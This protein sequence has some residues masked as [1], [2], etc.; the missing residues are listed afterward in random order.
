M[1]SNTQSPD[2][3]G[4]PSGITLSGRSRRATRDGIKTQGRV[5]SRRQQKQGTERTCF[6]PTHSTARAIAAE[7]VLPAAGFPRSTQPDHEDN[8][9]TV[10]R[11]APTRAGHTRNQK[12]NKEHELK[13]LHQVTRN[14]KACQLCGNNRSRP[15]MKTEHELLQ[16]SKKNNKFKRA[17]SR[18][19]VWTQQGEFSAGSQRCPR[20]PQHNSCKFSR[21]AEPPRRV[22]RV[23]RRWC[24]SGSWADPSIFTSIHDAEERKISSPKTWTHARYQ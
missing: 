15:Q 1:C 3:S 8:G 11:A 20:H 24:D 23:S 4:P 5:T 21:S 14:K 9:L 18:N 2:P 7:H 19:N 17:K 22:H 10:D 13:N 12:Q 6:K 16:A